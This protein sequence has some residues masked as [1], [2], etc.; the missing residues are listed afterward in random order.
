VRTI[1]CFWLVVY[2]STKEKKEAFLF[3]AHGFPRMLL[4]FQA[5]AIGDSAARK[6]Y[7]YLDC[8][9]CSHDICKYD[10]SIDTKRV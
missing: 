3:P 9:S 4:N 1:E 8:F 2:K 10:E 5:M 7:L 6:Q